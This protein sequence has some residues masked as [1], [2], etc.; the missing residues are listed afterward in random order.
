MV[1]KDA[2]APLAKRIVGNIIADLEGRSGLD[3]MWGSIEPA[4]RREI[5]KTWVR[6]A[7]TAVNDALTPTP[8]PGILV[9]PDIWR[10]L[11]DIIAGAAT[12]LGESSDV[13]EGHPD[14]ERKWEVWCNQLDTVL[15][16]AGVPSADN[17]AHILTRPVVL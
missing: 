13:L 16:Q 17:A 12:L 7:T 2:T 9:P 3:D 10:G 1:A 8:L 5:K 11:M 15:A 14:L 6:L 4:I